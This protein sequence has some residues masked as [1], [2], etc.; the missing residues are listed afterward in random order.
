MST[1]NQ[2]HEREDGMQHKALAELADTLRVD[3]QRLYRT[4]KQQVF[5]QSNNMPINDQQMLQAV[6]ICNA[7]KLNPFLKEIYVFPDK[8]GRIVPVVGVDGW[9]RIINSHEDYDG[10][11]FR[12]SEEMVQV[13]QYVADS[14]EGNGSKQ[15]HAWIE[16]II[17]RKSRK[18]PTV[19]RE[20]FEEVV[21]ATPEW[22]SKPKR[23]LR[24]KALI[25]CARYA[26]SF[27]N[28]YD[29][30]EAHTIRET[31]ITHE[32]SHTVVADVEAS[33]S[34]DAEAVEEV[35]GGSDTG[36]TLEEIASDV[37][38]EKVADLTKLAGQLAERAIK[39]NAWQG[40]R[41]W[42][43]SSL[44]DAASSAFVR[45]K[46]NEAEQH[47]NAKQAA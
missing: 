24:H 33:D 23:M 11:E 47:Y 39:E 22:V 28:L 13:A 3:V 40:A 36:P 6:V 44:P 21:R 34:F 46:L 37:S 9:N 1:H 38:P 7:Y 45:L 25:Q 30:D 41:D 19:I 10:M 43:D 18:Y 29:E 20:Y 12:Y 8:S 16:C 32:G 27:S 5:R 35:Q 14:K 4:L 2:T 17:H 42:I 31:D 15:C 26:F